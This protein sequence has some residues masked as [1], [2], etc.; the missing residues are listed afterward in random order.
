MTDRDALYAAILA[1]P[2]DDNPRLVYADYLDDTG[3]RADAIRARFIRNQVALSR[4]ERSIS[5][6]SIDSNSFAASAAVVLRPPDLDGS[7]S[8]PGIHGP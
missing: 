3:V 2:D 4:A 1:A 6:I 5:A 8:I 7:D